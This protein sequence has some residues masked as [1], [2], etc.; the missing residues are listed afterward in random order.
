MDLLNPAAAADIFAYAAPQQQQLETLAN[1]AM[2]QGLDLYKKKDYKGAAQSFQRSVNLAPRGQYAVDAT[3]YMANAYLKMDE[4]DKAI[5][6]Y[7]K[8]IELDSKRDDTRVFLGNL[9][10][11]QNRYQE[12]EAEYEAAVKISPNG[13]NL[14]SLGQAHLNTGRYRDAEELFNKVRK[15]DPK[16]P[17]GD[18]GLGQAFAKMGRGIEAVARFKEAIEKKPDFYDAYLDLGYAYADMGKMKEA[19]EQLAILKEKAP[20]LADTLSGYLYKTDPPKIM[21]AWATGNFKYRL[22]PKTP[23]AALD[24]YLEAPGAS[25]SFKMIFQF[26][27]EMDRSSVENRFNWTIKRA[28]G[29]NPWESYNFGLNTS[30]TEVRLPLHPDQVIYNSDNCSVTVLFT[31]R[32]NEAGN[33]TIDP[34][35]IEFAF[36]GKDNFGMT[37]NPKFDQFNGFSGTY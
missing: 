9:F 24:A 3:H 5:K 12:A 25:K 36:S 19:R 30:S 28:S 13:T 26:D 32:Q 21:F 10:F 37:M 17:N 6:A 1:A 14:Y 33:G 2:T 29:G 31:I 34:S 11:T 7:K 23:L 8:G 4:T 16:K 20:E 35:H 15:L 18:Y 27:K 22:P